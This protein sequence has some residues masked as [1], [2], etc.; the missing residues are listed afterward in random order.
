MKNNEGR[1]G[2][3]GRGSGTAARETSLLPQRD[4][5]SEGVGSGVELRQGRKTLAWVQFS[6][7]QVRQGG[8]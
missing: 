6:R 3:Q 8:R 5:S 1:K 7:N 4:A 2:K